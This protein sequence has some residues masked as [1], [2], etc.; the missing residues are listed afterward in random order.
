LRNE[1]V[2]PTPIDP[3]LFTHDRRREWLRRVHRY[4]WLIWIS[5]TALAGWILWDRL[6]DIDITAIGH[7]ILATSPATLFISLLCCFGV[8]VLAAAY[9]GIAVRS[10]T[11]RRAWIHSGIVASVAN[12]IGHMVGNALLGAGALRYRMHRAAGLNA[13]QIG[14]VIVLTAMPFLLALGWLI[15]LAMVFFADEAGKAL[16]VAVPALMAFGLIGLVKDAGWLWFVRRR[17]TPVRIAGHEIRI[18]SLNATVLQ[19]LIGVGEILLAAATLYVFLPPQIGLSLP[20]FVAVYLIAVM[21]GQLSHVPAGLGVQEAALMLMMPQVP[22][23][24]LLGAALLYRAVYDLLPLLVALVLLVT[25]ETLL[26]RGP[27]R[28]LLVA[29]VSRDDQL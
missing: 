23:A 8:N 13:A 10:V 24:E 3:T 1:H 7:R 6:H 17:A 27:L 20:T 4:S 29:Q 16:H 14:G 25:H 19:T 9:E 18:P 22:P 21:V 11:G 15:D 12:P 26:R 2:L 5:V 28:Q